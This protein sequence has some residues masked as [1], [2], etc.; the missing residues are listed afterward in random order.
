MNAGNYCYILSDDGVNATGESLC[1]ANVL[2]LSTGDFALKQCPNGTI[3]CVDENAVCAIDTC[4][5]GPICV[6]PF[7]FCPDG[8]PAPPGFESDVGPGVLD[9]LDG[10]GPYLTAGG[11]LYPDGHLDFPFEEGDSVPDWMNP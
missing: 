7:A 9:V 4:C 2:C 5:G 6:E 3:D 11:L 1:A 10:G 8:L